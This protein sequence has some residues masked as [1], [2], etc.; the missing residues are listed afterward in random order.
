MLNLFGGA[1]LLLAAV[2]VYGVGS[3]SAA[4]RRQELGVQ[5]AVGADRRSIIKLVVGQGLR[6]ALLG[7]VLGVSLQVAVTKSLGSLLYR[8]TPPNAST[9]FA[10]FLILLLVTASAVMSRPG[11]PRG[12]IRRACYELNDSSAERRQLRAER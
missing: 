3:F 11:A 2:G 1:G 7:V 9:G 6:L 8:L 12:L 5:M 10:T 4:Q